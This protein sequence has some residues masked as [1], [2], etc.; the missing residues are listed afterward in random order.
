LIQLKLSQK[1]KRHIAVMKKNR[2]KEMTALFDAL[3]DTELKEFL[4]LHKKIVSSASE[5][6]S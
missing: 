6:K 5:R 3:T 4:R 2:M 1:G